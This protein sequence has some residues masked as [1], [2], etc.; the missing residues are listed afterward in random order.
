MSDLIDPRNVKKSYMRAAL[1][2]HPDK[3]RQRGGSTPARVALADAVF[4]ALKGAWG[5]FE[6]SSEVRRQN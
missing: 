6:A 3:V 1:V 5:A 4:D 2:V